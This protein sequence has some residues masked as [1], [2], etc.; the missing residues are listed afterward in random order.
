MACV[1]WLTSISWV[2]AA[3]FVP[4]VAPD[5]V[6]FWRLVLGAPAT[7]FALFHVTAMRRMSERAQERWLLA[8][9]L[10]A[11][12][13]NAVLMQLTP[14]IWAIEMNLLSTVIWA[15]Y[16]LRG[17]AILV[18]ALAATASAL[19]P[20]LLDRS[21][22]FS[23]IDAA[24]MVVF[25]PVL[26]SLTAALYAQRRTIDEAQ[27]RADSLAYRDPLTGLANLRALRE[28]FEH[29]STRPDAGEC[30]LL[31]IDLDEFRQANMLYGHLGGDYVLRLVA[32]QLSR[33]AAANHLVA[34]IGGDE[35]VVLIPN[36]SPAQVQERAEFYRGVVVGAT[37]ELD[38]A[39]IELDASIGR[40][41]IPRDG[42]TLDEVLTVAER[43]MY[44]R[45]S[46]RAQSL[47]DK[48]RGASTAPP[49]L[50]AAVEDRPPP[51]SGLRKVWM[52]RPL[53]ARA[54]SVYWI[55]S[56]IV[57][58]AGAAMPG[59]EISRPGLFYACCA[60]AVT[61]GV[62]IF[63]IGVRRGSLVHRLADGAALLGM[64]GVTY[65]TGGAD[66]FM[67]PLLVIFVVYQSWF[68][69]VRTAG[70]RL[71]GAWMVILSPLL[72]DDVFDA[73]GWE[74]S[75]V[76][77]FAVLWVTGGLTLVLA[78]SNTVLLDF[79]HRSR[80]L[81]LI[82]PLTGI[83]N[84]RAFADRLAEVLADAE[85]SAPGQGPAILMFD[86]D[87]FKQVNKRLGHRAGD[88]LLREVGIAI[89]GAARAGDLVARIGGDEFA[90]VLPE[91][92]ARTARLVAE[93]LVDATSAVCE[94]LLAGSGVHLSA[95]VGFANAPESG[96]TLDE[97]LRAADQALMLAKSGV[98]GRDSGAAVVGG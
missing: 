41:S 23:E 6:W 98:G 86:L 46:R 16:F 53:Y 36:A 9:T 66:G 55:L 96:R 62:L 14:A 84:R 39:G 2:M 72:Y 12:G 92:D 45:K 22:D 81:A 88:E 47:V 38:L 20:A 58:L 60:L 1:V 25:I 49:W 42:R 28:M 52:S 59:A 68:W 83:P 35:F 54:V 30:A 76:F 24:R 80:R 27:R 73:A 15:A 8:S 34:R 82:D 94:R 40:A 95:S 17:R 63:A 32:G 89:A 93:R 87:N 18:G 50:A 7:A 57:M 74:L 71:I 97:L 44:D 78:V 70:R 19:S 75:A 91:A 61:L 77:L 26:W 21:G 90:A 67:L 65:L 48:S 5:D 51:P 31:L 3:S 69:S 11:A 33:A 13:V 37:M 43:S 85:M 64:A 56:A 29:V 10:A 4:D 79:R